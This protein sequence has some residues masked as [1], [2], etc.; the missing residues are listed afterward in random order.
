[1]IR[2]Y[3]NNLRYPSTFIDVYRYDR[4]LLFLHED[5]EEDIFI[6]RNNRISNGIIP[7]HFDVNRNAPSN[8]DLVV[9]VVSPGSTVHLAPL[10]SHI[11]YFHSTFHARTLPIRDPFIHALDR[12]S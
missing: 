2:L 10:A 8:A 11:E 4:P 3:S 6:A 1:M 9:V 7:L 5:Y 12:P